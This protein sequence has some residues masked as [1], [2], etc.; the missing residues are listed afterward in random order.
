MEN[1]TTFERALLREFESLA[2]ACER[3]GKLSADTADRLSKALDHFSG[4]TRKLRDRQT[5]LEEHLNAVSD[6]LSAQTQLTKN[7][8][9]QVDALLR[10]RGS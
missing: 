6:V 7:L 3:S 9:E 10:E 4:Q 1:L 2:A 5:A 8:I